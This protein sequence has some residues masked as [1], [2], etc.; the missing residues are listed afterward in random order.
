MKIKTLLFHHVHTHISS[1]SG[2]NVPRLVRIWDE[3]FKE[4]WGVRWLN[5]H[6]WA[7]LWNAIYAF[8]IL[9][10]P[11]WA[12][13][14]TLF[15]MNQMFLQK[16]LHKVIP[17]AA[18]LLLLADQ[19]HTEVCGHISMYSSATLD[20]WKDK[21]LA[22]VAALAGSSSLEQSKNLTSCSSD[23]GVVLCWGEAMGWLLLETIIPL[24]CNTR[25][26]VA[27][28]N[29]LKCPA[30]ISAAGAISATRNRHLTPEIS[31][32][33][34]YRGLCSCCPWTG[35]FSLGTNSTKTFFKGQA[36]IKPLVFS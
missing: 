8:E 32:D 3:I 17:T 27:E 29:F 30:N 19:R 34:H 10:C 31:W 36:T 4:G 1:T 9:P 6:Y 2:L 20:L 16:M 25:A 15:T 28:Q 18:A 23:S 14:H 5:L 24:F 33:S 12:R 21:I 7:E 35:Y 26:A 22:T 11:F 13:H